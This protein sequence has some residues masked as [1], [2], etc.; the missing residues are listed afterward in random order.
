MP[1]LY[2]CFSV[3]SHI[4][5]TAD[6]VTDVALEWFTGDDISYGKEQK[7]E[8]GDGVVVPATGLSTPAE[9]HFSR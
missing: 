7:H 5:M 8:S 2:A 4:R 6:D 3:M 1:N 9:Q